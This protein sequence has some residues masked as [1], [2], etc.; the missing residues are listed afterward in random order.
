[1]RRAE[2]GAKIFGVFRV[3]NH[4]FTPKKSYFSNFRGAREIFGVFH[5]IYHDFTPP[6]L[7]SWIRPCTPTY[8]VVDNASQRGKRKLVDIDG[9]THTVKVTLNDSLQIPPP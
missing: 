3:K 7:K 9:Y 5:V 2:G 6:N 1:V 8:T 4:D